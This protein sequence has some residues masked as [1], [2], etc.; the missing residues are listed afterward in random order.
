MWWFSGIFCDVNFV[1]KFQ[2]YIQDVFVMLSFDVC[3]CDVVVIVCIVIN[4]FFI[5]KVGIQFFDGDN[6]VI[7]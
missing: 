6:V 2:Y 1:I 4:V 7:E 5:Y 3:Y